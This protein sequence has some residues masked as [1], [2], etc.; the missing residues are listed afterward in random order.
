MFG[1]HEFLYILG[2]VHLFEILYQEK[3]IFLYLINTLCF[4]ACYHKIDIS[5][6]DQKVNIS[7]DDHKI[8]ISHVVTKIT[9]L[10]GDHKINVSIMIT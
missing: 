5:H 8:N 10:H 6:Y 4:L 9:T 2:K 7:Q 3:D 1:F